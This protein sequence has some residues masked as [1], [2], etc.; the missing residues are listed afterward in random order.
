MPLP[1][2]MNH[3]YIV[4]C[5]TCAKVRRSGKSS[6]ARLWKKWKQCKEAS[7]SPYT[8]KDA[9]SSVQTDAPSISTLALS[10]YNDARN[11]NLICSVTKDRDDY[12][13]GASHRTNCASDYH[14]AR[15]IRGIMAEHLLW[16]DNLIFGSMI[17]M[18]RIP[19]HLLWQEAYAGRKYEDDDDASVLE[20]NANNNCHNDDGYDTESDEDDDISDSSIH[21]GGD[22]SNDKIA[23]MLNDWLHT[24]LYYFLYCIALPASNDKCNNNSGH[25]E[26]SS[27]STIKYYLMYRNVPISFSGFMDYANKVVCAR[28]FARIMHHWNQDASFCEP[29]WINTS[30]HNLS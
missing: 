20:S 30:V 18:A 9:S 27:A 28:E 6:K 1:L 13:G 4:R 17:N 22:A 15:C 16:I 11:A 14:R 21:Y 8:L 10:Q 3:T 5:M 2:R 12:F 24:H 19:V 25:Q 29:M 23:T 7:Q 26:E